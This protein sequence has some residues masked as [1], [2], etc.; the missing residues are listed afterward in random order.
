MGPV[1]GEVKCT[2]TL[3][4][5]DL[6][7]NMLSPYH[8]P[9]TADSGITKLQPQLTDVPT[10]TGGQAGWLF[11]LSGHFQLVRLALSSVRAAPT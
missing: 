5:S 6:I 9:G 11:G 4:E 10:P 3:L 2:V 8:V 7:T 1:L